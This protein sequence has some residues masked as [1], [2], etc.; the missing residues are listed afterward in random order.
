MVGST[1]SG[2]SGDQDVGIDNSTDLGGPASVILTDSTVSGNTADVGVGGVGNSGT[3]TITDSTVSG[4]AA[5][6][7]AGVLSGTPNKKLAAGP[8]SVTIQTTETVTTLRGTKKVMTKT[9]V[10]ATIP[11]YLNLENSSRP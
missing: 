2:N 9:T 10:Q 8:S 5:T 7:P 6:I 4:N 1:V 11:L 3:M